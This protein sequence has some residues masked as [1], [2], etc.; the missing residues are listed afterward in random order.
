MA[1]VKITHEDINSGNPVTVLCNSLTVSGN[2]TTDSTPD[3]NIQDGPVEVQTQSFENL[4]FNI[5]GIHFTGD[6]NTLTWLDLLTL[7]KSKYDGTNAITLNVVYGLSNE[8]VLSGLSASSDISCVLKT[9]SFPISVVES[10]NGYLPVGNIT[11]IE[12]E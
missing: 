3:V 6:S 10:K 11:L 1:Y 5:N 9:I 8:K 7:Y 4:N 12:T 2:K